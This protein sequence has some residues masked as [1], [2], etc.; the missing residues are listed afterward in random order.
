MPATRTSTGWGALPNGAEW[1]QARV[2]AMTTTSLTPEQ[3]HEIGLKEV[4][5][6]QGEYGKIG[7]KM[8][9]TGPAAGLPRWVSEQPKYKPFTIDAAG[10]RRLSRSSTPTCA[11]SCRSC[12]R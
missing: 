7:P 9:Y 11:P 10:D 8:G 12:S 3:I 1:Y 4:A 5:R 6:I 2:A